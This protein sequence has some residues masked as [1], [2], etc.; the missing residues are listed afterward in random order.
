MSIQGALKASS[1][2]ASLVAL[3]ACASGKAPSPAPQID[4][5]TYAFDIPGEPERT[6]DGHGIIIGDRI[7]Y[8][9]PGGAGWYQAT[10]DARLA[11]GNTRRL[12]IGDTTVTIEA[13]GCPGNTARPDKVTMRFSPNVYRG[14]GGPRIIPGSIG[15]TTWTL[16]EL[17]R[18]RAPGGGSSAATLTFASDGS[19]GG[20]SACND[21][22][23][24]LRWRPGHFEQI[25][26]AGSIMTLV[27]CP[28]QQ[29]VEFG[30][31]FW[32]RMTQARTWTRDG[33]RLWVTFADGSRAGLA[34]IL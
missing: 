28:D 21:V 7:I 12:R 14:C 8:R 4:P 31:R 32:G 18:Q 27:G 17:D 22:G 29:S 30:G 20:T 19:I 13:R 23:G 25:I 9:T 1:G 34:L 16:R 33:A 6:R 2:V 26:D 24:G 15:G 11:N 5:S 3:V 10:I